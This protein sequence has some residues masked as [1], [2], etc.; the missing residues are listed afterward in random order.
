M[1]NKALIIKI[2]V[3]ILLCST[4]S[5]FAG[6]FVSVGTLVSWKN[7]MTRPITGWF[8]QQYALFFN[9]DE[10]DIVNIEAFNRVKDLLLSRYY[11]PVDI[12]ALLEGAVKGLAEGVEDPYT[13]YYNPEEM[14]KFMEESSGNYEGIGVLVSMDE[15]YLLTVAEV[16]PETPAKEAGI[17]KGD[18]IVKVDQEDVTSIRDPDDIVKKIKGPPGT[19]VKITVFREEIKDYI[20]FD[21]TR[22]TINVSY[23]SSRMLDDNIG[24]IRIKQFDNDIS[25]DFRNHLNSLLAEGMKGLVI[26]LRDNP[27]GDYNEVVKI[28]DMLLP[29]GLIVYVEDRYGNRREE[30]SDSNFVDI[31]MSVLINGY[32]ASASE[33]MSAALKDYQ[34]AVLVGTKTFGKGLVQQIDV[35]FPNGAGLKY[36]IAKYLTPSGLSIQD[37]GVEPD[38]EIMLD[39]EFRN[40]SIDDIPIEKDNQLQAA[41]SEVR[42]KTQ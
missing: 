38:I 25:Q 19:M 13:V 21:L 16:F 29:S 39:A 30:F 9:E 42:K 12:N 4:L 3:I 37:V 22:Q 40:T 10:V 32:S 24:Y 8:K 33:I 23:I 41:I 11:K 27:G 31:P 15:N 2:T 35:R 34:K 28:C 17:K 5:F 20:D 36:T 6:Y 14:K 18:K 26:D 7:V 1:R